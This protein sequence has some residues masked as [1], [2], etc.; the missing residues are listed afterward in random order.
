MVLWVYLRNGDT[1]IEKNILNIQWVEYEASIPGIAMR[2]KEDAWYWRVLPSSLRRCATTIGKTVWFPSREKYWDD[3][4]ITFSIIAHEFQHVFDWVRYG[5]IGF[6]FRYLFPQILGLAAL[7]FAILMLCFGWHATAVSLFG[8]TLFIAAP[9]PSN[10]RTKIEQCG[11]SMNLATQYL[12][13]GE[14]TE[15]HAAYV[16]GKFNN[17]FYYKMYRGDCQ[18]LVDNM[19]ENISG[20]RWPSGLSAFAPTVG[21]LLEAGLVSDRARVAYRWPKR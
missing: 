12:I 10:Q 2:F 20:P 7:V 14:V 1:M 13:E 5:A 19:I 16:E 11:Y 3:T 21:A 6:L 17:W 8:L 18:A 9:W 4:Q 15:E